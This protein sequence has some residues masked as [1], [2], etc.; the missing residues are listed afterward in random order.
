MSQQVNLFD[1]VVFTCFATGQPTP[2]YR[3][4]KDGELL[5]GRFDSKLSFDRVQLSDRGRYTCQA[6]NSE[7]TITSRQAL[8]NIISM[9]AA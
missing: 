7:G 5:D 4:L 8:L 2:E 1:T 3:W 9:C 6:S